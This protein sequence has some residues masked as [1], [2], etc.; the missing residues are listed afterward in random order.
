[1]Q[2]VSFH[3]KREK[4]LNYSLPLACEPGYNY[5]TGVNKGVLEE[6]RFVGLGNARLN[7]IAFR[8]SMY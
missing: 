7:N 2:N 1:M 5:A 6:N 4:I 3:F 8:I